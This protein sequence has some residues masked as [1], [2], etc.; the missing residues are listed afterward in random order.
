[1]QYPGHSPVL[2]DKLGQR[3]V[4]TTLAALLAGAGRRAR[5]QPATGLMPV[6]NRLQVRIITDSLTDCCSIPQRTP[7]LGVERTGPAERPG[8]APQ[9]TLRAE[10]GLHDFQH[11]IATSYVVRGWGLMSCSHRGVPNS[12]RQAMAALGVAKL[13]GVVGGHL[14]PPLDDEYV[15]QTV[16]E[17]N[18]MEPE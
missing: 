10:W 1:M 17:M 16:A 7:G 8:I 13:H 14:P 6:M 5:A 12:V 9:A 15:R 18:A 3:R 2:R 11:E 4:V